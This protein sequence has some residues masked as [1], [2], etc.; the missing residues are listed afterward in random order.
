MRFSEDSGNK[1]KTR[2]TW[3]RKAAMEEAP[4]ESYHKSPRRWGERK[5]TEWKRVRFANFLLG[6]SREL[7]STEE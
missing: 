6:R 4:L 3:E 1:R 5:K 2:K 7:F